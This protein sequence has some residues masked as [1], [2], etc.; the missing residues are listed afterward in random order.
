M[1]EK[2]EFKDIQINE[3]NFQGKVYTDPVF[4][5]SG[6]A[7]VAIVNL[8]VFTPELSANGQWT[9]TEIVVPIYVMESNKVATVRKHIKAGRRLFIK[10][11]YKNWMNGTESQH[12][13]MATSIK[14][15]SKP[16]EAPA[17][18]GNAPSLPSV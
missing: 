1:P 15:G 12:G 5:P 4:V 17:G 3:C 13:L 8:T 10:A 14:L 6:N 16:Y 2:K 9:E 7:E 18:E 11:Y